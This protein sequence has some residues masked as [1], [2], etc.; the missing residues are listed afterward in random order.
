MSA[1]YG[2]PSCSPPLQSMDGRAVTLAPHTADI[3]RLP[4]CINTA[5]SSLY[6]PHPS[7]DV[8]YAS[9]QTRANIQSA[10]GRVGWQIDLLGLSLPRLRRWPSCPS[11]SS[12]AHPSIH[13]H[14]H[15]PSILPPSAA[16]LA[17][18]PTAGRRLV[19]ELPPAGQLRMAVCQAQPED[20]EAHGDR[21]YSVPRDVVG[22]QAHGR[23][24]IWMWQR[25]LCRPRSW[26]QLQR[27]RSTRNFA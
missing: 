22:F 17:T 2:H 11:P 7:S 24:G 27:V 25:V 1:E 6:D 26:R 15:P 20:S 19:R 23:G 21:R 12:H 3:P 14:P 13:P 5:L 18:R 10:D 16:S 4:R 9:S 8:V